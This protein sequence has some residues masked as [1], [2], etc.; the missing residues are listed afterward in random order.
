MCYIF[1]LSDNRFRVCEGKVW[2][3]TKRRKLWKR[4][5]DVLPRKNGYQEISIT[6]KY[7]TARYVKLCR[8]I[9]KAHNPNY[10]IYDKVIH[11]DGNKQNNN[12][13]NLFAV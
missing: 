9:Y 1:N 5:D 11:K 6:P 8:I 3:K 2:K 12:I 4:I 10:N 13:S 7:G